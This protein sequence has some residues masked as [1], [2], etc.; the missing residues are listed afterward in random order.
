VFRTD[1]NARQIT[2]PT[3][4]NG[5]SRTQTKVSVQSPAW[6][7][8][9]FLMGWEAGPW[10]WLTCF[11]VFGGAPPQ[12]WNTAVLHPSPLTRIKPTDGTGLQSDIFPQWWQGSRPEGLAVAIIKDSVLRLF[13]SDRCHHLSFLRTEWHRFS[14]SGRL[15]RS[16][17][18]SPVRATSSRLFP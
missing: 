11:K 2:R 9:S 13:R 15:T 1:G 10:T 7:R 12:K 18:P 16:S 6:K 3:R 17:L 4:G 14:P 5:I 8:K